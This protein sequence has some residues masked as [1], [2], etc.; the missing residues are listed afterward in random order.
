MQQNTSIVLD[1][2]NHWIHEVN[3]STSCTT[4][5]GVNST[6]CPNEA[7]CSENC[8]IEGVDYTTS[9]VT[10]SGDTLTLNQYVQSDGVTSNASP[11]V[12]LLGS[13]G[14][15][16]M[17][18]LLG[19]ELRF[20]VDVSTLVCGENGA[21]YLSEMDAS[22]GRSQYNPGGAA[23]GSGYCDAQCPVETWINGTL[24]TDSQGYCCNEMDIC[25]YWGS[26]SFP[27]R[28][29]LRR[30]AHETYLAKNLSRN[31]PNKALAKS[32]VT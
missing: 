3:S 8:V 7:T 18:Q 21:L 20:D 23:Y 16:E 27:L 31:L 1:W 26:P 10:V 5:S 30:S 17:L 13:N 25:R 19:Q 22:G 14:D 6:L 24:N 32:P 11:R 15:Y 4:S 29:C 12:Y 9:G 28:A 2:N